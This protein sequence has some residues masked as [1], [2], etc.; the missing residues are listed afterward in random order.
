MLFKFLIITFP[1]FFL[2]E[3]TYVK[4]IVGVTKIW[5]YTRG[6]RIEFEIK[7]ANYEVGERNIRFWKIEFDKQV[8]VTPSGYRTSR[9]LRGFD[10][11]ADRQWRR[12]GVEKITQGNP[13]SLVIDIGAN[14]GEFTRACV[15]HNIREIHS[16]EPDEIPLKC[17]KENISD[18]SVR[19][20]GFPLGELNKKTIFYSAPKNAD[21]SL[22]KPRVKSLQKLI[23]IQKL[24][25]IPISIEQPHSVLL[26]MDA[27]GA[28][29]EVLQGATSTLAKIKWV[30]IDIGPERNG[31]STYFEVAEILEKNGF[32]VSKFSKWILHGE[33]KEEFSKKSSDK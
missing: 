13:I 17:L 19:I 25:S 23:E 3:K 27:E 31:K 30:V 20:Y 9:F 5:L 12:Y 24:D 1:T 16:F 2:P 8:V 33:K 32:K 22:I 26:K 6:S 10:H 29:P 21:S 7:L 28:E 11:A 18:K 4:Y 15:N 14:I